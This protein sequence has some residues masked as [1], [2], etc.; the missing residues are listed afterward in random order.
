MNASKAKL[1]AGLS[2]LELA[3][4]LGRLEKVALPAGTVLFR[5]GDSGDDMYLLQEGTIELSAASEGG[6]ERPLARLSA[7]DSLGEMALLTGERRSATA[8]IGEAAVL[9]RI[10]RQTFDEVLMDKPTVSA[11]FLRQLSD[12]L[13]RSNMQLQATKGEQAQRAHTE[14]Q[15]QS[16]AHRELLLE[17]SAFAMFEATLP[18][19]LLSGAA[20]ATSSAASESGRSSSGMSSERPTP[21][22]SPSGK[23][24]APSSPASPSVPS[25]IP[26]RAESSGMSSASLATGDS[27]RAESSALSNGPSATDDSP[28]AMSG[29][30]SSTAS[31]SPPSSASATTPEDELASLQ[32]YLLPIPGRP[33]WL[34]LEPALRRQLSEL[35]RR[36]RGAEGRRELLAAEA[37]HLAAVGQLEGALL[38]W[39][40]LEDWEQAASLLEGELAQGAASGS[41]P[42]AVIERLDGCPA[43]VLAAHS[44]LLEAYV[45]HGIDERREPALRQLEDVLALSPDWP[46][47]RLARLYEWAGELSHRLD[48]R[49]KALEYVQMAEELG[50]RLGEEQ[51]AAA[52]AAEERTYRLKRQQVQRQRTERL[53]SRAGLLLQ[54]TRWSAA[55]SV[56]AALLVVL[57]F[58]WL[59][60]LGGLSEAAMLFIGVGIA[61]VILWI[62]NIIPDYLVALLMAM[63]WVLGG[64]VPPET[65]LSGFATPTW[66]YMVFILA[67]GAAI[68][69][70]GILYRLSLHAL[71]RF[72]SHYRGQL[73]GIVA[74]GALLNPLI[75]SSSAKVAL[76]VPVA[77]TLSE[78]MGFRDRSPG[79]AGLGLAAMVFYGFTAPFVLT[80]SYTNV[81]AYGL[82][83]DGHPISWFRWF[84]YALPAFILFS[85][86]ILLLLSLLFRG[87]RAERPISRQT[88][89]A[90]LAVLGPFS[91]EE[92]ITTATVIG[93]IALM[94]AQP[95]HGVDNAWVMLL[96][97]GVLVATGV[98]DT[99]SLKSG[100]DWPF[101]IFIGIA[102]SFAAAAE[103]LGIVEA[104]T[105]FLGEHMAVFLASPTLFLLAVVVLSFAVTLIIRDDPAVILLVIALL[106]LA[107]LAGVHPWVLVFLILLSTDPF[108]FAYQS[109]TYLMAYYSTEGKSFS[110]RQ[111][112]WMGL[113]YGILVLLIAVLCVPYWQWLGLIQ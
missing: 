76:G 108:F 112:G 73:W 54:R 103:Q 80:G 13:H 48:Q 61:A 9:Y 87:V 17:L 102:F 7:G 82:V 36:E 59:P 24:G 85:A 64:V 62:V 95:L 32:S 11:Y 21:G 109:P 22:D 39:L 74:G 67:L 65:A 84:L 89:D 50:R 77:S 105:G 6:E 42:A 19:R 68:T 10:D 56:A 71:R 100:V 96:G 57:L 31:P 43:A 2:N 63:V 38:T 29:A 70:S 25:G 46:P 72:P 79:A 81:M 53:A 94:I 44:V 52:Q 20:S 45:L 28:E 23:S 18:A 3:R 107:G 90:Q 60:P 92:R 33:G 14:L 69:R 27:S 66:L 83:G 101:L 110:H 26:P 12:R 4:I 113:G 1:F 91:R 78:S 98:L 88:L 97:F 34:Q 106:P 104:M 49:V 15:R 99:A 55:A 51:G 8:V 41:L 30:P 58:G 5:Q 75:P 47:A 93:C 37:R 111:G 86:G 35:L 16:P 40:E